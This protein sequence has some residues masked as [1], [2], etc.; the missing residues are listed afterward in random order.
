MRFGNRGEKRVSEPG[1][2]ADNTPLIRTW[3]AD[4]DAWESLL[5][6][7]HTPSED[8][9]IANESVVDD[10]A[11]S[12]A[13]PSQLARLRQQQDEY[14]IVIAADERAMTDRENP[15]LVVR[16]DGTDEP[17]TLRVASSELWG[18]E[19]N[20]ALAN[21]EWEDFSGGADDDGV[22]RGFG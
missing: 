14:S 2:S 20:L 6:S 7:V 10:P 19:N 9:F 13:A 15:L 11:M 8:G 4:D 5:A 18:I 12:K 1:A 17:Q 16:A 22:F 3:F 21:M